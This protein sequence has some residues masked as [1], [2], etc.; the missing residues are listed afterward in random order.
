MVVSPLVT[1]LAYAYYDLTGGQWRTESAL[2]KNTSGA[3]VLPDR[4]VLSFK[5]G[6]FESSQIVTLPGGGVLPPAF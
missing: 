5:H 1:K 2:R 3:W 4:L 6:S